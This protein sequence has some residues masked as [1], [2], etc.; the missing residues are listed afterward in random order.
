MLAQHAIA[1]ELTVIADRSV[2]QQRAKELG[3]VLEL[4]PTNNASVHPGKGT[5]NVLHQQAP[6]PVIAGQLD[7][8]NSQY[9]LDTLI[10]ATKGCVGGEFDA[11]VTAPVHK[12]IINEAN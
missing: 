9:V 4:A 8:A 2:L 10:A 7:R 11:M 6:H 12:G 1:A 3:L 5:L